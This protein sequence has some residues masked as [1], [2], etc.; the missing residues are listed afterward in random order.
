MTK[1]NVLIYKIETWQGDKLIDIVICM[2]NKGNV[3]EKGTLTNGNGSVNKYNAD[4]KLIESL[5][6]KNGLKN[7]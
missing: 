1:N 3:L 6:Y 5:T 4:G 2:D 7:N